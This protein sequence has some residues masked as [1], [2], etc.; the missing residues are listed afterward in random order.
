VTDYAWL[1]PQFST[2]STVAVVVALAFTVWSGL[3]ESPR[4]Y[5][6]LVE[7]RA[8]NRPDVARRFYQR[9][10]QIQFARCVL[11]FTVLVADPGIDRA[12]LGLVAPVG[13]AAAVWGVFVWIVLLLGLSTVVLRRR[14]LTG[15]TVPGQRL[16][17]AI[18]PRAGER[19]LA[20]GLALGAGVSEELLFRGLFLAA[21]V[22][23][24]RLPPGTALVV[25][26]VGFGLMHL[27][28]GWWG[29]L[30]TGLVGY[31]FGGLYLSSHS[32]LIPVLVHI[33]V[34]L[35]AVLLVPLVTQDPNGH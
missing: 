34:D 32:L 13:G 4:R 3:V 30:G 26:S 20:A 29:V 21:A 10:I 33:L 17:D 19:P 1:H 22:D 16:F 18:V 27:Y 11:V 23:L 2:A 28:Q 35:R 7:A 15:R 6:A 25:T 31:L 14:A 24:L 8:A 5:R 9:S 12:D